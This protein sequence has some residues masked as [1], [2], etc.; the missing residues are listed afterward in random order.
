[1]YRRQAL[2]IAA[3]SVAAVATLGWASGEPVAPSLVVA[4][5]R[6]WWRIEAVAAS[7]LEAAQRLASLNGVALR[8]A[9][10]SL[11]RTPALDLH[12]QGRD[13]GAA[14]RALLGPAVNYA[15][16]CGARRCQAWIV[17]GNAPAAAPATT[18]FRAPGTDPSVPDNAD[19][20]PPARD[21][22]DPPEPLHPAE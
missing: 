20:A 16:R 6:G 12:W 13:A 17:G 11:A 7:R 1:M 5:E 4:H 22:I 18:T 3:C 2:R 9:A 15:L 19:Q 14:W 21:R 10:A 8:C